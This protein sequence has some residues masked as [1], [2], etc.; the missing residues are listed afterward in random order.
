MRF[1]LC[2]L[3]AVGGLTG[4]LN[5]DVGNLGSPRPLRE[6]TV[7]GDAGPKLAMVDVSGLIIEAAPRPR[8]LGFPSGP[9]PVAR[10]REALDL[11][12]EDP[13][14]AA[15]LLRI[16]SPGGTVGATETVHHELLRWKTRTQRPVIAYMDGLA[17]S[18]G[19]YVAMAAD[20]IIAQPAAVTGSIGVL[21]SGVNVTGLLDRFGVADQS[22]TSGP[23][24][25]AGSPLRDMSPEEAAQLQGVVDDL[26]SRFLDVVEAGRP[27]LERSRIVQLSDGRIYT[28]RQALDVGLI[29]A[30]GHLEDAAAAAE[31]RAGISESRVVIYRPASGEYRRNIY[32]APNLPPAQVVELKL[33]PDEAMLSPGFYYLWRAAR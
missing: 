11:A 9:G 20:E 19:Y 25:D 13:D 2:A 33:L 12:A 24:K 10:L 4:C 1:A 31:R 26:H 32:S 30:I 16:R 8:F 5:L 27:Q 15:L 14:V 21:L 17:T 29:D 28:A 6:T 7:L 18:G 23:Y 22:F 3:L